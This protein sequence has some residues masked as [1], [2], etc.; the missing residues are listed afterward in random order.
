MDGQL[1]GYEQNESGRSRSVQHLSIT[2]LFFDP[3]L[4]L[5]QCRLRK[6]QNPLVSAFT[7]RW[8]RYSAMTTAGWAEELLILWFETT[9]VSSLTFKLA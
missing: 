9:K 6:K 2:D 7:S 5:T 1:G 3:R 4:F 8:L